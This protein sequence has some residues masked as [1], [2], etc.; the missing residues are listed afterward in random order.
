V[1]IFAIC[2]ALALGGCITGYSRPAPAGVY[3]VG[4]LSGE[5]FYLVGWK[6]TF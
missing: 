2:L 3:P 6:F 1:R 5:P 4:L